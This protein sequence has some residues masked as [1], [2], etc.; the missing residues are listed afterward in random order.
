MSAA[1]AMI[2]LTAAD[3]FALD[4]WLARPAGAP[5]AGLVIAQEMYGVT[6]YLKRVAAFYAAQGYLAVVPALYD[7]RER[8]CVLAYNEADRDRVHDLYKSMDWEKSL[9]DLD[10]GRRFAAEAGKVAIVGF[11]WGGSLAWMAACRGDYQAAVAY[12]GSA[13]PDYAN[14]TP[15][16]PVIAHVG[17][18]DTS[19]PP[20]RVAAFRAARPETPVFTYAGT[21]HGF[22][23][24]TRPARYRPE[25]HRLARERTLAF[26]A[27]HIG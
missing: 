8:D 7:R 21:P 19:F 27:R 5:K 14:E 16:C 12:Y 17:D 20:A 10:A 2:R 24:E 23:N 3:G 6:E 25:A 11:C 18:D 9:L 22:D 15:R 13:M 4:A 26:L 1:P